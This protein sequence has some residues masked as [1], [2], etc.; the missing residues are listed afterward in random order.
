MHWKH[1]L[2]SICITMV[3]LCHGG[4]CH[5]QIPDSTI[6]VCIIYDNYAVNEELSTDWGFGAVIRTPSNTILFDTG[7]NR[8]LLLA[9]MEKMKINPKE[10]DIVILS[11]EHGDHVGGLDGFLSTNNDV[12]VYIPTSFPDHIRSNI[13]SHNAN[14][15]DITES[16]QICNFIHTTG[17]M[18]DQI[19]E[20]SVILETKEGLIIITG[21]AHPGTNSHQLHPGQLYPN[22]SSY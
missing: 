15:H 17:E 9:N 13:Q 2:C 22:H 14:Y 1:F 21:C 8:S 4:I 11:H 12:E 16:Q 18:G 6:D 19:I 20:H 5:S 3:S 7:G 10:I